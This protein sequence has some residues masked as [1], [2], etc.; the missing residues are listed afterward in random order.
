MWLAA[1]AQR[2]QGMAVQG[3]ENLLHVLITKTTSTKIGMF[4]P[5][6]AK[7]MEGIGS[8]AWDARGVSFVQGTA[9]M[10]DILASAKDGGEGEERRT[11]VTKY[12]TQ[13]RDFLVQCW[14]S[15]TVERNGN[16]ATW[17]RPDTPCK[18]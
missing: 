14:V 16:T 2:A 8:D 1:L 5:T 9:A 13:K 4:C 3:A 10:Q 7:S 15:G 6:H 12:L 17:T 11:N 18:I